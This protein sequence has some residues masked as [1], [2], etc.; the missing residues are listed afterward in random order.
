MKLPKTFLPE[1][2]LEKKTETLLQENKK[3][4]KPVIIERKELEDL[5]YAF[6]EYYFDSTLH[7]KIDVLT[8]K[9]G[10]QS[11]KVNDLKWE[12]WTKKTDYDENYVFTK[13]HDR[14]N[15]RYAFAIVND[16][17]L[18]EFCERFE[19][20]NRV[21]IFG[22]GRD[23]L[24][25][26]MASAFIGSAVIGLATKYA[27]SSYMLRVFGMLNEATTVSCMAALGAVLGF[28]EGTFWLAYKNSVNKE[29][30]K[31]CYTQLIIDDKTALK[32]AFS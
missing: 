20:D 10:Y 14:K 21:K 31:T 3:T 1:R 26:L 24:P 32:M 18:E 22:L 23:R 27:A 19:R 28:I 7:E 6:N 2:N 29:K 17:K 12:Y 16:G 5:L 8:R 30:L 9:S 13:W 4:P 15:T 25:Y 11:L